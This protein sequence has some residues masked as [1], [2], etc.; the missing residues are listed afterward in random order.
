MEKTTDGEGTTQ[1]RYPKCP[2]C[3]SKKRHYE[4]ASE[5]AIKMGVAD[6]G[7]LVPMIYDNKTIMD[8]TKQA[9]IKVGDEAPT[10]T[11]ALEICKDCGCVY[12][13]MVITGKAKKTL[14]PTKLV[15]PGQ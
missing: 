11:A 9:S 8:P 3:G 6:K 4:E 12:A 7:F 5:K 10:M 2:A 13:P 14:L 1:Y 15:L